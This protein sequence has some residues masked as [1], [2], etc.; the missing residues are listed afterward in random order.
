M[1]DRKTDVN[2]AIRH[3]KPE[4]LE[5]CRAL[6]EE[7]TEWHRHIYQSPDIG[8]RDPGLLFDAH[9]DRVGAEHI[10]VAEVG[11][12]VVGLVGLIPEEREGELEPLVVSEPYRRHGIGKQLTKA[13]IE[14]ARASG[15][16]ALKVQ[17]VA[18]NESAIGF[19]HGS[20]FNVL[21]EIEMFMDFRPADRQTWKVGERVAGR[22]FRV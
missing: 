18:R 10:W 12:K 2:V 1:E 9:L 14:A 5:S 6:W 7:L 20:G 4:D 17:P 15:M 22:E 11:G 8:G 19:F 3:Y 21:G 16:R 13:V